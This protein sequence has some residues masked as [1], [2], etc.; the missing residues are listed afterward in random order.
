M[1][2][3]S[4]LVGLE[5][6]GL[7]VLLAHL[8]APTQAVVH[9]LAFAHLLVEGLGLL[10][11]HQ[12]VQVHGASYEKEGG[13]SPLGLSPWRWSRGAAVSGAGSPSPRP[14]WCGRPS[15]SQP[16]QRRDRP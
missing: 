9:V 15:G 2:A 4:R 6:P 1:V 13:R 11:R 7:L 16:R 5:V 3:P 14:G 8:H 12:F 10:A